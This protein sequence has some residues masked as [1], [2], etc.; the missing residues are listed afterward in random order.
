MKF[1]FYYSIEFFKDLLLKSKDFLL[2]LHM[3]FKSIKEIIMEK[4]KGNKKDTFMEFS[5]DDLKL[6]SDNENAALEALS[7]PLSK[8]NFVKDSIPNNKRKK[9]KEFWYWSIWYTIKT[10]LSAIPKFQLFQSI[11]IF[12][13]FILLIGV[14]TSRSNTSPRDERAYGTLRKMQQLKKS[15]S[16]YANI[17][18]EEI[19]HVWK[20]LFLGVTYQRDGNL[21]Y[22]TADCIGAVFAF[23]QYYGYAGQIM[24]VDTLDDSITKL[25]A[26]GLQKI[27]TNMYQVKT[28]DIIIFNPIN[29]ISHVGIVECVRGGY[30][31]Y[32]DMNG[33][34]SAS[35]NFIPWNDP[36]KWG[37]IKKIAEVSYPFW[38]GD[39]WKE[40]S[41][42]TDII[43]DPTIR[44]TPR[45]INN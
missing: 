24:N 23:L 34:V 44:E 19:Y 15:H 31:L 25:H 21:K 43:D 30:I 42:K 38:C 37:R 39:V 29:G 28:G 12:L 9:V 7:R 2:E 14:F 4:I 32:V 36:G 18:E 22:K 13:M 3:G 41:E 8:K 11:A 1:I 45:K 17:T 6:E 20:D 5:D 27:R 26:A 40:Y 16:Y 33:A 10:W 35:E